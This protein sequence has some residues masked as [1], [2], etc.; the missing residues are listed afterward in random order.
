MQIA[1]TKGVD[2]SKCSEVR[3]VVTPPGFRHPTL[4]SRFR[5]NQMVS[6]EAARRG[7]ISLAPLVLAPAILGCGGGQAAVKSVSL[8]PSSSA[9]KA[10]ELYDA[11][12]DGSLDD[13]ELA[14]CPA[15]AMSIKQVDANGD[16][17]LNVDEI[18]GILERIQASGT[19][20]SGAGIQVTL[21]G[22]PLAGATVKVTPAE[23]FEGALPPAEGVTDEQGLAHPT[24]GDENLPEK[25]KGS[26]LMYPGL[27]AVEITHADQQLPPRY[28]AETELG[29]L[30]DPASREGS[31]GRF[32]LKAN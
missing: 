9:A 24:I 13:S 4:I 1:R 12:A 23:F 3:I 25:L 19:P 18:R 17:R 27:Y 10:I 14:K 15:L 29:L 7:A 32:D 8:N 31:G 30:I 5:S 20:L 26:A 6:L 16:H 2:H 21:A 22:R 11:N 28:N